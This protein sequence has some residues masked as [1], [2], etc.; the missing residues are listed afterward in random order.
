MLLV[1]AFL[2]I[3]SW[4]A[5]VVYLIGKNIT[6]RI[7]SLENKILQRLTFMEMKLSKQSN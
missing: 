2:A 4:I 1:L 7:D 5:F 3:F 6:T